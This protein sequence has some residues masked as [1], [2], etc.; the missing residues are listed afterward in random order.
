M[1]ALRVAIYTMMLSALS[2][3]AGFGEEGQAQ[4][5]GAGSSPNG[6]KSAWDGAH[7]VNPNS[8]KQG[9]AEA[10]RVSATED[11]AGVGSLLRPRSRPGYSRVKAPSKGK[12]SKPALGAYSKKYWHHGGEKGGEKEKPAGGEN[13]A[14]VPGESLNEQESKLHRNPQESSVE[15]SPIVRHATPS[16]PVSAGKSAMRG[17]GLIPTPGH[18]SPNPAIIGGGTIT[19]RTQGA[20]VIGGTSMAGSR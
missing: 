11:G 2:P 8:D 18:H 6:A 4:P 20:A 10:G 1:K 14:S 17:Q 13:H 9:K 16:S 5:L 19:S 3:G 15:M 7:K 12:S